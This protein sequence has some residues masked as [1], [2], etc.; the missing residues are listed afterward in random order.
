MQTCDNCHNAVTFVGAKF[1]HIGLGR[2]ACASCHLSGIYGLT[3]KPNTQTHMGV[4][5][6]CESCHSSTATWS[7][8]KPDHSL[9]TVATNC[10]S[11]HVAGGS[12]SSFKLSTHIPTNLNCTSCHSTNGWKPSTWNHTQ[13]SV[14]NQCS[15]CHNGAYPPADPPTQNHIRY[16]VLTGVAI[17]NCDTC[18]KA[19]Y[20]SWFPG[21]F[22]KNV[23][24]T[25]QCATCH[26]T[27]INGLTSKPSTPTHSMVTGNCESCHKTTVSWAASK[28]DHSLFN[29][30][31]V[32]TSCHVTGGAATP[33]PN[34]HMPTA[35]NCISCHS[36]TGAAFTPNTWNHTQMPAAGQCATCHT[37]SYLSGMGR[38]S[39]HIPYQVLTGVAITNCDSCHKAGYVGWFPGQFHKNVPISSQCSTCHLSG[40]YGLTAKPATTTHATITG[41]CESCHSNPSIAWASATFAHTA[42]NAVGTGTCDTCHGIVGAMPPNPMGK[43]LGHIPYVAGLAKC[44]S[45]HKS[46]ISFNTSV[47]MNH[48]VVA[49]STCKSCHNGSYTSAGALGA[50]PKP[51]NHI[52]EVQLLNGASMDCKACHSSTTSFLTEKMNH[53]GSLGS[54]SGQCTACHA[55][56]TNYLGT[57]LKKTV[58]HISPGKPDCSTAGCHRP[59]GNR[60]A[61]YV[62]W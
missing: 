27:A 31:T 37:G 15:T 30:A 11:C 53:N 7:S 4:T 6:N 60:G 55:T 36:A 8:A 49:T 10:N 14:V 13:Q 12:T 44:D 34:N 41:N 43:T 16:Q 48:S 23:P 18:H 29:V 32:C 39:N 25:T 61:S 54:G 46:Q 40:I 52:P 28:T 35:L 62:T 21:Q 2:N 56:G 5:S 33:K 38:T 57:M 3:S 1:N 50:L 19:G 17:T 58:N 42:A 51:T 47:T 9:F 45:C 59:L 20:A 24:I 22:H 26:L